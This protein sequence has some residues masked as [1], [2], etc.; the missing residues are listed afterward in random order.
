MSG[1]GLCVAARSSSLDPLFGSLMFNS[2]LR[3][4]SLEWMDLGLGTL[5][6]TA[7]RAGWCSQGGCGCV[8]QPYGK[9]VPG[10][11]DEAFTLHSIKTD[12]TWSWLW[13]TVAEDLQGQGV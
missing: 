7:K 6:G 4:P 3:V 2:R 8:L 11:L 5:S 13:V 12:E 9:G 1:A 10:S